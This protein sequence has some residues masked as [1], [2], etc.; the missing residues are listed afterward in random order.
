M[1]SGAV[2]LFVDLVGTEPLLNGLVGGA[3]IAAMNLFG[4]SLVLVWRDPSERALDTALGFAAGVMLAAAFTSLII[5]GIEEYSGGNPVP[6]LV[7]V[8]LGALFLDRADGLVPHAHYLLTGNRRPD[9]A[10]PGQ[11]LSVDE[12][13]LAAVILFILAI[14]L[15]NIPEGLAVSVAAINAG[16]DRRLYAVF[17]GIRSGVVNRLRVEPRRFPWISRTRLEYHR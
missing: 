16:L 10:N 12:P 2:E 3:I 9:A 4:A 15:H 13:K 5:P 14:T 1:Q 11:D 6:T 8:A 17:A 7:G